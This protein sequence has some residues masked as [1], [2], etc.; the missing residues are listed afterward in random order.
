M[1]KQKRL[2]HDFQIRAHDLDASGRTSAAALIRILETQRW[3]A[4]DKKGF[5]KV[6][7]KKGVIRAQYLEV[8]ET[9]RFDEQLEVSLRLFRV[10][11]SSM[12]F[13]HKIQSRTTGRLVGQAA[14][15]FVALDADFRPQTLPPQVREYISEAEGVE[16]PTTVYEKP[17]DAWSHAF[18]VRWTDLDFMQHVNEA[19]FIEFI[20][21]TRHDCAAAMGFGTQDDR[22]LLPIGRLAI[23][24]DD[25]ARLGDRLRI[26]V[27]KIE[28]EPD[29]Y[30]FEIRREPD[31]ALI[32]RAWITVR[33]KPNPSR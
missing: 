3:Y 20:E 5:G 7:F 1:D 17:Q 32:T 29:R 31:Q 10:G 18:T 30:A 4:F 33:E 6:Y 12:D 25:Q 26:A 24:Y 14:V 13:S 15:R 8:F 23:S 21:N 16:L 27:W 11:R 9:T 28:N 22:A 19:R 2:F